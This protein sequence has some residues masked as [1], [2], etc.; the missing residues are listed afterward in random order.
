MVMWGCGG[1]VV[2]WCGGVWCEV[3]ELGEM[4]YVY[5]CVL[6]TWCVG[7]VWCIVCSV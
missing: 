7:M 3:M 5:G 6:R 1:V 2:R 4:N